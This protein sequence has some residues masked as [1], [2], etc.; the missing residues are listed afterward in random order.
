MR[1]RSIVVC[2]VV[3]AGMGGQCLAQFRDAPTE[4]SKLGDSVVQRWRAGVIITARSGPCQGLVGT[5]P[6]P[7]DWPEQETKIV[8][9]DFS[10]TAKVSY[11]VVEG[12]VKQMVVEIPYLP[13]GEECR[14][15]VTVE[16][17]RSSQVRPD[18]TSVFVLPNKRKLPRDVLPY[19]APSPGIE[20]TSAKIKSTARQFDVQEEGAW[21][22]IEAIYDW[23]RDNVEHQDKNQGGALAAL[24]AGQ[25]DH[26]D[27]TSLFIALCRAKNVPARTVWVDKHCYPEFYLE[28]K[29]GKGYWFPCQA[30]GARAFGEMPDRATILQ[31]GDSF[32]SPHDRRERKRFLP[33]TLDGAGGTPSVR[34]IREPAP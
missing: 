23:V 22:Q 25:G 19:L 30:G 7:T 28:D 10:P 17:R 1:V 18:D 11:R 9:E 21:D 6:L 29:E 5:A 16:V 15:I 12:T 20:C 14:A 2:L 33:E 13:A 26:E 24:Q 4:G 27:L 31:K 34:F 8:E 32:R 3:V